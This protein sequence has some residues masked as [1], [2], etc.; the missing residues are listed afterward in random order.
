MKTQPRSLPTKA[1]LSNASHGGL[2]LSA[3]S[4]SALAVWQ[5]LELVKV[6]QGGNA[7]C[8]INET[9]NCEAVWDTAFATW[10]QAT[11]GIPVAAWGL[12][13]GLGALAWAVGLGF[14]KNPAWLGLSVWGTRIWALAGALFC[15]VF[16]YVSWRAGSVCVTCLAT[17]VLVLAYA[18][19]AVGLLSFRA[20]LPKNTFVLASLLSLALVFLL[21]VLMQPFGKKTATAAVTSISSHTSLEHFLSTLKPEEKSNLGKAR[22]AF[23]AAPERPVAAPTLGRFPKQAPVVLQDFTDIKCGHCQT[24]EVVLTQLLH[25][26]PPGSIAVEPR[27]YPLDAECNPSLRRPEEPPPGPSMGVRC[28]AALV[29]I[30]LEGS[31][32]FAKLRGEL[33]HAASSLKTREDVLAIASKGQTSRM[34][35]ESCMDSPDALARLHADIALAQSHGIRGTP[36]FLLNGKPVGFAPSF[37]TAMALAKGNAEDLAFTLLK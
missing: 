1:S 17:F 33:F 6:R 8:A 36:F 22:K 23:L 29:Q 20:P 14:R 4:M 7:A 2:L 13:W 3:V 16:A 15:V 30:C 21:G 9:L 19:C 24:A 35:L 5:W 12:V 32:D 18:F 27:Y 31:A 11:L 25:S 28:A 37:W 34:R 26:M 10:V